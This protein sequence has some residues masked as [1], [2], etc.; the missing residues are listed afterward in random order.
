MAGLVLLPGVMCDAGLWQKVES[1]LSPF[2]PLIFG[3]LSQGNSV[4]EMAESVL[5]QCPAT[6]TLVGFS[7][8]GFVAREILRRVPER[9]ERLI[10]IATSSQPDS[11]RARRAKAAT[12]AALASTSGPFRGL[13]QKAIALSLSAKRAD[14]EAL[15]AVIRAM[16]LRMGR[17]AY[18]RQLL[19]TRRGDTALLRQ[20]SCPTLV[21][22][23]ADDR[24]RTMA[25]SQTLCD[26]IPHATLEVIAGSGHMLPLEQPQ[27]LAALLTRWL[28]NDA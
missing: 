15:Q 18:R 28:R 24:M 17:E 21:V 3:D 19:M 11:E 10:L 22:A 1:D 2:G 7:M 6:F 20:I 14:D 27:A 8:G 9:V 13:G 4:E 5:Q 25:E 26:N 23:A 16:S 12:A